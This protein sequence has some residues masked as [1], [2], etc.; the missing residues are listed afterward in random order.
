MPMYTLQVPATTLTGRGI[1]PLFPPDGGV[2]T[3]RRPGDIYTSICY[4]NLLERP[5]GIEP[6]KNSFAGCRVSFSASDANSFWQGRLDSNQD[7][8]FWR[9]GC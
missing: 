1:E 9:P 2:L 3:T 5:A 6:A 7:L 8:W 4:K